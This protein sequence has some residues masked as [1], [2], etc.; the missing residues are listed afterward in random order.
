M[1]RVFLGLRYV[2]GDFMSVS[3]YL[4][5]LDFA[6]LVGRF[7]V[8]R[9]DELDKVVSPFWPYNDFLKVFRAFGARTRDGLG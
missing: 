9:A 5:A 2:R 3:S 4:Y 8:R 1:R 7:S 6:E